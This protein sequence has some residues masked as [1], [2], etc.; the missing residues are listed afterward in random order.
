MTPITYVCARSRYI[1]LP[2][3]ASPIN[4]TSHHSA[5]TFATYMLLAAQ[6]ACLLLAPGHDGHECLA[7]RGLG[8]RCR[9]HTAVVDTRAKLS[10]AIRRRDPA[11]SAAAHG[12]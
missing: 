5:A 1:T 3:T 10:D 2:A 8:D 6:H 9:D 4:G 12:A 11:L 7:D